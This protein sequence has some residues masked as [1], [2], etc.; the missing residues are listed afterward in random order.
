M[1]A[2]MMKHFIV[3]IK[4]VNL[5]SQLKLN[6]LAYDPNSQDVILYK[7][8]PLIARKGDET[9]SICN[10]DTFTI[11]KICDKIINLHLEVEN[12]KT[13]YNLIE[14]KNQQFCK[15]YNDNVKITLIEYYNS[16]TNI[17]TNFPHKN[18]DTVQ[19]TI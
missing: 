18:I 4:K 11:K 10:N 13:L 12:C 5:K 6:K 19:T 9:K 16:L 3:N 8:M 1:N 14:K 2:M 17:I 15:N 7:D